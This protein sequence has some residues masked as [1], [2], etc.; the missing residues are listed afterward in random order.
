[1]DQSLYPGTWPYITIGKLFFQ[2]RNAAGVLGNYACSA[3]SSAAANVVF[4]AGHCLNG[5][6]P[7]PGNRWSQN[8]IFVPAY[9][10]GAQ[11][12]GR[13]ACGFKTVA[14]AWF[15]SGDPARDVGACRVGVSSLAPNKTLTQSVGWLG[16]AW[17]QSR[18]QHWHAFGYPGEPPF[19]GL[20]MIVCAASWAVT[21]GNPAIGAP[22]PHGIGCDM[23]RGSSG[24]PWVKAFKTGNWINGVNSYKYFASQPLAVYSPYFDTYVNQIRCY[25]ATGTW[26]PPAC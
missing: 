22:D 3:A 26:P 16:F 6:P 10:N 24:G 17:N 13:F 23:N 8:V 19:N 14:T 21:D 11:P 18:F 2:Q 15:V 25:A 7:N 5:G 4:T 9:E 1:V 20:L 12:Y